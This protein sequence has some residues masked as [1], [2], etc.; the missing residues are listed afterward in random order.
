ML[1]PSRGVPVT[2]VTP[3]LLWRFARVTGR[4]ADQSRAIRSGIA[5]TMPAS[6]G[7]L[8]RINSPSRQY[9]QI[10]LVTRKGP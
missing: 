1:F 3:V 2:I 10:V 5:A 6:S 9:A 8:G 4:R 7:G